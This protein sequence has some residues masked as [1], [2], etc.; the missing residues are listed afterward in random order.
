[1]TRHRRYSDRR[2]NRKTV[3]YIVDQIGGAGT[4]AFRPMFGEYGLYC[5][6]KIIAIIGDKQLFVKP[7][8]RGRAMAETAEEVSP[9]PG[10]KPYLLIPADRWEDQ[11]WLTELVRSTAA[12]LAMP[13]R[14]AANRPKA[15]G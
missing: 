3:E 8:A 14:K 12:E 13:K 2:L 15:S 6:G 5:D 10:A 11:D 1:M 7:T 4:V 9:Y